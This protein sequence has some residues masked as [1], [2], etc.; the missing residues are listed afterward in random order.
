MA[1]CNARPKTLPEYIRLSCNV[2]PA[3]EE[4][5]RI[6]LS[7]LTDEEL[8]SVINKISKIHTGTITPVDPDYLI[9]F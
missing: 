3:E 9:V 4:E 1:K 2:M 7:G 5:I 8:L 6:N